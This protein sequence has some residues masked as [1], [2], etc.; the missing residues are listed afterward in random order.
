MLGIF[1]IVLAVETALVATC[2]NRKR[3]TAVPA[4][5]I[6]P[7]R[8][9]TSA[10]KPTTWNML[11]AKLRAEIGSKFVRLSPAER[12]FLSDEALEIVGEGK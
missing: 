8:L 7:A 9:A 4:S 10:A 11:A 3:P 6:F 5:C 2:S 1:S 12:L